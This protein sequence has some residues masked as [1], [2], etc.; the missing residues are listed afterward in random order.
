M[1]YR[2]SVRHLVIT[3]EPDDVELVSG[4]AWF[5]GCEGIEE[6]LVNS[7]RPPVETVDLVVAIE[8]P[9][10]LLA[11][12]DGRWPT[13]DV[14]LDPDE[15]V[16]SW[17]PWAQAV[18]LAGL[19]VRPPW[20]DPIG[21]G[22]EIVIDPGRAWG[23]GAHATTRLVLE[24]LAAMQ[25]GGRRVLDVGCGSGVLSIAAA[26]LGASAVTAVDVDPAA[27]DATA[28]NAALNDVDVDVS[29]TPLSEVRGVY[30]LVLANI[31]AP[32][33]CGLGSSF[34]SLLAPGGIA[35]VSGLLADRVSEVVEAC[36]P[37]RLMLRHDLDGWAGLRLA[38]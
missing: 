6:R 30:D 9:T 38:L 21:V 15:W 2:R 12:L 5:A 23:H 29:A 33:L 36:S 19:V 31:D 13:R 24:A 20:L 8:D 1:I 7:P 37:L 4:L 27:V 34:A 18:V 10:E 3:V 17:K 11:H 26:R 35:L 25:L 16:E 22:P 28:S 14:A 32:V